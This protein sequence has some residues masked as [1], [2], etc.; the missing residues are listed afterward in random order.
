MG[1]NVTTTGIDLLALG[2]GTRLRFLGTTEMVERD[3]HEAGFVYMALGSAIG[4]LILKALIMTLVFGSLKENVKTFPWTIFIYALVSYAFFHGAHNETTTIDN[5][6]AVV[7]TGLRHPCKKVDAFRKGLLEKCMVKEGKTIV[8]R[9]A[10]VMGVV[11]VGGTIRPGM[12]IV[13]EP[14]AVFEPMKPLY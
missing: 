3:Q 8:E 14:T 13:V 7:I 2:K 1:E 5:Q 6:P 9:K 4:T 12:I 10:G 11:E